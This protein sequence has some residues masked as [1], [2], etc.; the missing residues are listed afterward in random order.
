[1][2]KILLVTLLTLTLAF[3]NAA[4]TSQRQLRLENN[5]AT[6]FEAAVGAIK[7]IDDPRQLRSEGILSNLVELL[8]N[9]TPANP[10][11]GTVDSAS[12]EQDPDEVEILRRRR[13]P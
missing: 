13:V 10:S 5:A 12:P 3:A 11:T 7:K 2:K 4:D 6:S 8:K 9:L 1:M